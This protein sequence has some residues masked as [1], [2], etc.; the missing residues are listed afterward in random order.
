MNFEEITGALRGFGMNNNVEFKEENFRSL[1]PTKGVFDITG[2]NVDEHAA[3]APHG[4]HQVADDIKEKKD[5]AKKVTDK[6]FMLKDHY[7]E[8]W[9]VYAGLLLDIEGGLKED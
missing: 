3:Q 4:M 1:N 5:N 7:R 2:D 9:D 6:F 8:W